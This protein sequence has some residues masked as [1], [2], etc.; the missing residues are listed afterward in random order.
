MIIGMLAKITSDKI[1]QIGLNCSMTFKCDHPAQMFS[2]RQLAYKVGQ[3]D[4][5]K[6]TT[7]MDLQNNMLT[8]TRIK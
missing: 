6:Y 7:S 1:R 3:V 5:C 2:G 8:I 4:G